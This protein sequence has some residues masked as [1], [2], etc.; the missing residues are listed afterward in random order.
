MDY[1]KR[2]VLVAEFQSVQCYP[3][4]RNFSKKIHSSSLRHNILMLKKKTFLCFS[5]ETPPRRQKCLRTFFQR[6]LVWL[7]K[8]TAIRRS[9]SWGVPIE[10][11]LPEI[12]LWP[13][14]HCRIKGALISSPIMPRV[15]S[16]KYFIPEHPKRTPL[17]QIRDNRR[18]IL[19][20]SYQSKFFC[21][22]NNYF[23]IITIFERFPCYFVCY[24]YC[25]VL[26]EIV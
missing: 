25:D 5:K 3:S 22:N 26:V 7:E 14:Q 10:E 20:S 13:S 1:R 6:L 17:T 9:A 8:I 23:C 15:A 24:D 12:P 2:V 18:N 21:L 4:V 16:F 19:L 11:T